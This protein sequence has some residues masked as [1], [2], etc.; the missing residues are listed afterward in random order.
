[1]LTK[2]R[3]KNSVRHFDTSTLRHFDTSTDNISYIASRIFLGLVVLCV[4]SFFY[5]FGC[6]ITPYKTEEL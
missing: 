6:D 3:F 1:M 2:L 4:W 5:I